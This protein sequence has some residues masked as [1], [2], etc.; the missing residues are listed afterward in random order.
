MRS[1][2]NTDK[3][4]EDLFFSSLAFS[5]T[6]IRHMFIRKVYGILTCQLTITIAFIAVFLSV[7]AVQKFFET[8]KWILWNILALTVVIIIVLACFKNIARKYPMNIILLFVFT[9]LES[10]VLGVAAATYQVQEVLIAVCITVA[11]V[12]GIIIF[13]SQ[14]KIDFIGFNMYLFVSMLV[15]LYYGLLF[16]ILMISGAIG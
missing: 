3:N 9:I 6:T 12:I 2:K 16:F 15:S 4:P 5:D 13:A 14:T 7:E 11:V 10:V 8:N 1:S